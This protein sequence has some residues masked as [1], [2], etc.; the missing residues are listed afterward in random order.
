[1][2]KVKKNLNYQVIIYPDRT[3]GSNKFCF[4]AF[5]PALEVADSGKSIE[6]AF[7]NVKSLIRFHLECLKKEKTAI[8]KSFVSENEDLISTAKVSISF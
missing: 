7:E 8:P 3:V 5:C 6:E 4:T 1:M 2:A